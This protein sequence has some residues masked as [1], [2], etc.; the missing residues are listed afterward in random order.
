[1]G[2][3]IPGKM[4]FTGQVSATLSNVQIAKSKVKATVS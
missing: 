2:E 3:P 4:R 1:M